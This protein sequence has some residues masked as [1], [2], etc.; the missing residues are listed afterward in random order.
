MKKIIEYFFSLEATIILL[1]IFAAVLIYA[2]LG[3]PNDEQAWIYV[4]G[5]RWFELI[6]WLI[7]INLSGVMVRYKTYKKPSIFVI[8]VAILVILLGAA[9]TRYFGYSGILHLRIGQTSSNFMLTK[10]NDPTATKMV[11][12]GFS[13]RLDNFVVQKYPGSR[14][15]SSYDSY[16]TVID[17]DKT[18]QYHIYMNHILKYKGYRI[19]QMSYDRDEMGSILFINHDPGMIIT[20]FGYFL[21]T[22]GFL[23]VL[24][25]RKSRFLKAIKNINNNVALLILVLALSSMPLGSHAETIDN[26]AKHSKA[27]SDQWSK[28]LVQLNG[29][30]EP[31]DTLDKDIV[32]KI[33]KTSFLHKMNYNQ[34]IL[35]MVAYP[36]MFQSLKMI[37]VGN[38]AIREKLKLKGKYAA[39]NDFFL[40]NGDFIFSKEVEKALHK[41]PQERNSID[42]EWLKINERIYVAFSVYTASIF[43]IFPTEYSALNNHRWLSVSELGY[44]KNSDTAKR[45]FD[46]FR[47]LIIAAKNYNLKQE[48]ELTKKIYSI[49]KIYSSNLLPSENRIKAEILYNRLGIFPKLIGVY[50]LLGLMFISIGF[51]EILK[52]K[53]FKKVNIA[54]IAAGWIAFFF[55]TFNMILRW[56]AS[57]H[58]PWSDAYESIVFI[59]WSA[60]FVSLLFFMRNTLTLGAGFFIAGMFMMVAHLNSI[61]PQI[62]NMVPVLKSYWLLIHVAVITIGYGFLAVSAMLS[63]INLPLFLLNRKY[64]LQEKIKQINNIIYISIY[65]GLIFLTIG[66]FLGGIWANESWGRYWSWDPKETW[67]L[68]TIIAYAV[69]IHLKITT[70]VNDLMFSILAFF[71]FFFIL[72]TYF[73]VNFYIA[74]GLHSYGRGEAAYAWFYVLKFG[75]AVWF[76]LISSILL[77][78]IAKK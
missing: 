41:S 49:Q 21:L 63:L 7:G 20:Y 48:K 64:S 18:F 29:R 53:P 58:L 40:P 73:G 19:Y 39:Y 54:L 33:A 72:M 30:I 8:H 17:K 71:S 68:I 51:L 31:M 22:I 16:I 35:G 67:S 61:D 60:V 14:Q 37:Y 65:A 15:P 47:N 10:R 70:K 1:L 24:F 36:H 77:L 26:W 75:I 32:N 43:R 69:I 57:G 42:R 4:Y 62:T 2:T 74:Q 34:I 28:I 45:Y 3:F 52:G 78:K 11:P 55:H 38:K 12:L 46:L 56:Y 6:I 13:I 25:D 23:L 44:L 50:S 9:I 59:A 27:V 76:V 66:T 5:S